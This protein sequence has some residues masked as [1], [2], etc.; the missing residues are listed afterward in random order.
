MLQPQVTLKSGGYIIINQTEALVSIDVNSGRSTKEHSIEDTALQTNLEAAEEVAR[1]LRLRDLAGLIVIDFIDMEENRNN[2]AVEKKLKDCLKNDRARIQ[3]GRISHFG[4]L[5]MSRQ[6]IRA[7][8]LESTMKPCPHCGGTGHVRSDS[9]VALLVVRAIEEF[10]LKDSKSHITVRT[11]AA[12]ALYVLNHKRSK[13]VELETR[14]GVTITLETDET[15]GAQH[16]AIHRGAIAE[17]PLGWTETVALPLDEVEDEQPE[18]DDDLVA[19]DIEADGGER[20]P[21]PRHGDG[22]ERHHDHKRRRRRRRRGGRDRG[23]HEHGQ[24]PQHAHRE[25]EPGDDRTVGVPGDLPAYDEAEQPAASAVDAADAGSEQ[26]GEQKKRRRGKRGG[27]RNRRD[28]EAHD[29]AGVADVTEA[30][31]AAEIE[32]IVATFETVEEPATIAA[33]EV[34]AAELAPPPAK[35]PRRS[36]AKAA[37]AAAEFERSRVCR[38]TGGARRRADRARCP[39]L[40]TGHRGPGSRCR[41]GG[42]SR[43]AH[44]AAPQRSR[45]SSVGTGRLLGRGRRGSCAAGREQAQEGRLVAASELFLSRR[46]LSQCARRSAASAISSGLPA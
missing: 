20:A 7:S 11:P 34:D 29:E 8:V 26:A 9:S 5:E 25:T 40:R 17:K 30:A 44:L 39:P 46:Y 43:P 38:R 36:R 14:F 4:L 10:L 13:L 41:R 6:R 16:Y 19:D 32:G 27:K 2:R 23:E 3:V 35:K 28:E 15:V 12:T 22:G 33:P 37:P 45:R 18:V 42:A 21:E 31:D 1:Q 24:P